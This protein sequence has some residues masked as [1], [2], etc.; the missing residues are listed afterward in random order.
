[1]G[2]THLNR[3]QDGDREVPLRRKSTMRHLLVPRCPAVAIGAIGSANARS[4]LRF[5]MSQ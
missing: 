5:G 4:I 2:N 3:D 1:M